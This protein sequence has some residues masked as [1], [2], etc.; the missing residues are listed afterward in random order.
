MFSWF[1]NT[2]NALLRI[3][4]QAACLVLTGI[5][6]GSAGCSKGPYIPP[7]EPVSGTVTL[8]GKPLEGAE[9]YFV[10]EHLVAFGKTDSSGHYELAQGAVAGENKVYFSK[11]S[12]GKSPIEQQEGMDD[13]QMQM[14]AASGGGANIPKQLIPAE[15]SDP[16]APKLNYLVPTGG[17]KTADFKL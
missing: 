6:L 10:S 2:F 13:Y 17:T 15:Y 7:T 3:K 11:M 8:K 5:L 9:V 16:A 14:A 1:R 12:P 4:Q